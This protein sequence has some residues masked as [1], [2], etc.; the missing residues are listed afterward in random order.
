[1]DFLTWYVTPSIAF[2]LELFNDKFGEKES[3]K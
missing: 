3:N 1:M 2:Y